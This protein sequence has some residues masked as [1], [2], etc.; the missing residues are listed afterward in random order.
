M[1]FEMWLKNPEKLGFASSDLD[2]DSSLARDRVGARGT[3]SGMGGPADVD[4]A[5]QRGTD[6][7]LKAL[8]VFGEKIVD[9]IKISKILQQL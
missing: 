9:V 7:F 2:L 4:G 6:N 3:R 1:F 8:L 5:P